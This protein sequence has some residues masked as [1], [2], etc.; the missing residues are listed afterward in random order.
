MKRIKPKLI[1]KQIGFSESLYLFKR[2]HVKRKKLKM[3]IP[4]NR[5]NNRK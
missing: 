5:R 2:L 4:G 1:I 3:K